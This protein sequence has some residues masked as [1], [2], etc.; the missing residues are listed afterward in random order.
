MEKGEEDFHQNFRWPNASSMFFTHFPGSPRGI[1]LH[2]FP[3]APSLGADVSGD[4]SLDII[5]TLTESQ[6]TVLLFLSHRITLWTKCK[7]CVFSTCS[8]TAEAAGFQHC[9]ITVRN[10][11]CSVSEVKQNVKIFEYIS[12][13][14]SSFKLVKAREEESHSLT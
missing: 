13:R 3:T 5:R 2:S 11:F 1:S 8:S 4:Y 7:C 12:L 10:N 6:L 14:I 9:I